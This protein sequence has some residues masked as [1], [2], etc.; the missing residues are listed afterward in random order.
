MG[1]N[2]T[3]IRSQFC[4]CKQ[5]MPTLKFTLW[6]KATS[7]AKHI[8]IFR[9]HFKWHELPN[10]I[11]RLCTTQNFLCA[12]IHTCT[13]H[14]TCR[15]TENG[16]RA[17]AVFT[18]DKCHQRNKQGTIR[19]HLTNDFSAGCCLAPKSWDIRRAPQPVSRHMFH[20]AIEI[21]IHQCGDVNHCA[22]FTA[23]M[24]GIAILPMTPQPC[25]K[26][27]GMSRVCSTIPLSFRP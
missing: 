10:D 12:A 16:R 24:V 3:S 5:D 4:I 22:I 19:H 6:P 2:P 11:G 27:T 25:F 8:A 26:G 7:P 23:H 13:M 14:S 17:R 20:I 1:Y 9:Q 21:L 15:Q 18:A